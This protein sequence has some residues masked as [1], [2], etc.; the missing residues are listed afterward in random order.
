MRFWHRVLTSVLVVV[1]VGILAP[2]AWAQTGGQI[3]GIVKDA[4][5]GS[6]IGG[7]RV[8]LYAADGT[9]LA[10]NEPFGAIY[11]FSQLA[12][13]R[14]L[15]KV[16]TNFDPITNRDA[17][18]RDYVDEVYPDAVCMGCDVTIGTPISVIAGQTTA[19]VDFALARGGSIS[20]VVSDSV[21]TGLASSSVYAYT[22]GRATPARHT[23]VD[24]D[25]TGNYVIRGL[26]PG[27]YVVRTNA[28][29]GYVFSF[30]YDVNEIY[31]DV[32]CVLPSHLTSPTDGC[33]SAGTLVAVTAGSTRS[34]V[35]F[36]LAAGGAIG[37]YINLAGALFN[38]TTGARLYSAAG[39]DLG[40]SQ[41]TLNDGY[42]FL[43]LPAG[44]YFVRSVNAQG[45]IDERFDDQP[46]APPS[47]CDA[48]ITGG[49]PIVVGAGEAIG[50]IDFSL[51]PG[52]RISGVIKNAA[53]NAAIAGVAVRAF[54][55]T[56]QFISDAVSDGA[57]KYVTGTGLPSGIYYVRTVG[58]P[59]YQDGLYNGFACAPSCTVTTGTSVAVTAGQTTFGIDFALQPKPGAFA[60]T[61]PSDGATGL[62]TSVT[63]SWTASAAATSYAY[64]ID[65]SNDDACSTWISAGANTSV[66]V[67]GL[68]VNT[69]YFW[70]VRATNAYGITY[71]GGSDTRG[72]RAF[73]TL[74][75][76]AFSK[77]SPGIGVPIWLSTVTLSWGTSAGA[78]T[79]EYCI[80][81]TNDSACTA[82][83]S[84]GAGTSVVIGNLPDTFTRFYWHVRAING[85]G[86]TY[87]NGSATAFWTFDRAGPPGPFDRISPANGSVVSSASSVTLAW[88][89]SAGAT[90]YSYCIDTSNDNNCSQWIDNGAN[91]S[92]TLSGLAGNTTYYW[93]VLA[94]SGY[95]T[96]FA[97]GGVFAYWS[98]TTQNVPGAFGK[99][100]PANGATGVSK[101]PTLSWQASA[102]AT[103]YAI[104]IGLSTSCIETPVGLTTSLQGYFLL[105]AGT[106]YYW[107]IRALNPGGDVYANGSANAF[108]TFTTGN[109]SFT[110]DPLVPQSTPI[111]AVHITELRSRIDALRIGHGLAAF[112]WTDGTVTAGA[113]MV[114]LQHIIDLR[115][116]LAAV[117][118][119]LGRTPPTY[120]EPLLSAGMFVKAIHISELRAAVI[121]VE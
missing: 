11:T 63:L 16:T 89:A 35:N 51:S 105:N 18:A 29:E 90:S 65:T 81:T 46:C 23:Y 42:G 106:T 97:S 119:A 88:T 41:M 22:P 111:K 67:N 50:S 72:Y 28:A 69:I 68:A 14:Y 13:G 7:F 56:G 79:Y 10:S 59:G 2:S 27:S 83:T 82:W 43:P 117:Y 114:R 113:T 115:T 44:T 86:A 95:D 45:F 37:G 6:P 108:W 103:G 102:G 49:T 100:A 17:G 112:N 32:Q 40:F 96:V 48:G 116:A 55:A 66:V 64:C 93:H 15:V 121:A 84:T 9:F 5:T 110:D 8:E 39:R 118:T 104:C 25:A 3:T 74:Y 109:G 71:S 61:S 1:G 91:T 34:G 92:V 20:G 47:L 85:A 24:Y 107:Q 36:S 52:G 57:G 99:L 78:A 26:A 21:Y 58:A 53:T 60:K 101:N 30:G 98:F 38:S 73:S 120:T 33:A 19:N 70:H 4:A 80:D 12:T 76:A 77:T 75:P 62:G 87:A 31:D 94:N 54:D